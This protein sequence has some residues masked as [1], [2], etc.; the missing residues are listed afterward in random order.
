M[1]VIFK[2]TALSIL[3]ISDVSFTFF[4]MY[5]CQPII[6]SGRA[7]P[8][9]FNNLVRNVLCKGLLNYVTFVP[10]CL[11]CLRAY[12]P[13]RPNFSHAYVLTYLDIFF[14]PTC[15]RALN[16]FVPTCAHFSRTYA[17]TATHDIET[18]IYPADVKSDEN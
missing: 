8:R 2:M 14:V 10:T 6:L 12:V 16:Y 9:I 3:A 11:T 17:P 1:F 15:L 5:R 7:E 18:D 13:K 4:D